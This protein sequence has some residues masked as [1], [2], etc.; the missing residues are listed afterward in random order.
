[1]THPALP[2][3]RVTPCAPSWQTRTRLLASARRSLQ[4][5]IC[6]PCP[7]NRRDQRNVWKISSIPCRVAR[8]QRPLLNFSMGSDVEIRQRRNLNPA[9]SA[10][11]QKRLRCQPASRVW[12][13]Q[14]LKN[15]RIKPPVQINGTCKSRSRFCLDDRVD[16]NRSLRGGRA[17]LVFRPRE[18]D[19]IGRRNIQQHVRVKQIHSSTRVRAITFAVVSPGRAAPRARCSQPATGVGVARLTRSV[20][21]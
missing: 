17:K 8:D 4:T 5:A 10:I 16:K 18:P 3:G 19:R 13:R 15:R 20:S 9:A 7:S 14:P 6:P 21:S 12:Q 1:M 11:F 2:K